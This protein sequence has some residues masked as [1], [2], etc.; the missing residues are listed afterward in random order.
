[1]I[2]SLEIKIVFLCISFIFIIS[3]ICMFKCFE[4]VSNIRKF[5]VFLFFPFTA[6]TR[7]FFVTSFL[8]Q[9]PATPITSTKLC[10]ERFLRVK[11]LVRLLNKH[12]IALLW[13]QTP[14]KKEMLCDLV[15]HKCQ[16]S[17]SPLMR[18]HLWQEGRK[19]LLWKTHKN[20]LMCCFWE[21]T[22]KRSKGSNYFTS[23][24]YACLR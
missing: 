9:H 11:S 19:L 3:V 23:H 1:M 14:S 8:F 6:L 7:I 2:I 15:Q 5:F 20:T 24:T 18:W 17:D 4:A 21:L 12:R 13:Y 16:L 10:V 22:R